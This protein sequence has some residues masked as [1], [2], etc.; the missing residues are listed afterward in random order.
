MVEPDSWSVE[1][2]FFSC[3]CLYFLLLFVLPLF[4]LSDFFGGVVGVERV[5]Y[6]SEFCLTHLSH[7]YSSLFVVV[8]FLNSEIF[9]GF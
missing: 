7:A 2:S 3:V 4:F 1:C 8:V 9:P 5:N 6:C